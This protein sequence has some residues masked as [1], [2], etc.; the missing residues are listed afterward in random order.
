MSQPS[1][2]N[3]SYVGRY[4]PTPNGLLHLGHAA[5]FHTAYLR[6]KKH[7]GRILL[8]IEDL[9][10]DR[11]KMDYDKAIFEDLKWLGLSWDDDLQ[12]PELFLRQSDRIDAYREILL[13]LIEAD[14]VY[15]CLLSRKKIQE[16]PDLVKNRNRE[17]I[18]PEALRPKSSETN[19]PDQLF[20]VNWRFRVEYG[21]EVQFEDQRTGV[22]R[23]RAGTDFGD[24]LIWSKSG[25]PSYE[26]AV[27]L[28]DIKSK[29]TEIVRGEDL[30]GSTVRQIL[31]YR[32]L[33]AG[34]PDFYHCPLVKD[35]HGVR[36]A[37]QFDSESLRSY[38]ERGFTPDQVWKMI[39]S[40]Y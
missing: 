18:F 35:D 33:K 37:K 36:L 20:D 8:R 19:I 10:R 40:A 7:G 30:L 34:I 14:V 17:V 2:P 24:F 4:A 1:E 22:H 26:L 3:K 23:Y 39:E 28:D 25:Y 27:V 6:A 38:R 16:Y 21:T 9:D 32:I 12:A 11:W 15:P 13:K 31:L 29:I 5:T